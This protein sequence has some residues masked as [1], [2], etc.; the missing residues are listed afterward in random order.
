MAGAHGL[1]AVYA[2]DCADCGA[3]VRVRAVDLPGYNG[4]FS[5]CPDCQ[6]R[7][8]HSLFVSSAINLC[9]WTGGGFVA[10]QTL[11][12]T[13]RALGAPA[14]LWS[15]VLMFAAGFAAMPGIAVA[16]AHLV[17]FLRALTTRQRRP[18]LAGEAATASARAAAD[19]SAARATAL[20]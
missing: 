16:L 5:E 1:S 3:R 15:W 4:A 9:A 12:A 2:R 6:R 18:A 20:R 7:L 14:P 17:C 10:L 13:E 19:S 8:S 11:R